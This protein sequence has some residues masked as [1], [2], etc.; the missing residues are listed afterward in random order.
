MSIFLPRP[1]QFIE[2]HP[3][4]AAYPQAHHDYKATCAWLMRNGIAIP[5]SL[6]PYSHVQHV[7]TPYLVKLW[8]PAEHLAENAVLVGEFT[9]PRSRI[10]TLTPG[11]FV[12]DIYE[13]VPPLMDSELDAMDQEWLAHRNQK[14]GLC[15]YLRMFWWGLWSRILPVDYVAL[16]KILK[17]RQLVCSSAED[18]FLTDIGRDLWPGIEHTITSPCMLAAAVVTGRLR[19]AKAD[20]TPGEV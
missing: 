15:L 2:C 6:R 1:G 3:S 10:R 17:T 12:A 8:L 4:D 20:W 18:K 11:E 13:L 14:Y 9:W 19:L 16:A 7:L 5:E